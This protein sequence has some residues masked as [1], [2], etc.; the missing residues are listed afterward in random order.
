MPV[1]IAR[2]IKFLK[3]EEFEIL[4]KDAVL[5]RLHIG[6]T[7]CHDDDIGPVE[8][9]AR[10]AQTAIRK[11][12]VSKDRAVVL[13]EHYRHRR[14][15]IAV[16][17]SVIEQYQTDF[18]I[19]LQ[20]TVYAFDTFLAHGHGNLRTKLAVYLIGLVAYVLGA[21]LGCGKDKSFG[22]TLVAARK[23]TYI[24]FIHQGLDYILDMRSLAGAPH[25]NIADYNHRHLKLLLPEHTL[26]KHLVAHSHSQTIKA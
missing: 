8:R 18:G 14:L 23:H 15:D 24:I 4:F 21:R 6:R 3:R 20:H 10:L 19:N 7:F 22:S 26:L 17:E 5:H 2:E 13:G 1:I 9:A 12:T 16:L 25:G 11:Q